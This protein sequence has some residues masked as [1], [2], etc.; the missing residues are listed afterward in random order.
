M[1]PDPPTS[2]HRT[3]SSRPD[4]PS[5]R[6]ADLGHSR[7]DLSRSARLGMPEAVFAAG[8]Q[9]AQCAEI[10]ERM[11]EESDDPVIVTRCGPPHHDALSALSPER[12]W[13]DTL[14]W[15]HA[16]SRQATVA[17]VSGGTSDQPV[18]DECA[19]TLCAMGVTAR[20]V[21]DVGVAGLHRL[22][23]ALDELDEAQVIVTIAGMEAA[24]PT[25]LAGLVP[26]PIVSVPTSVGYGN[27][28]DGLT[29]L[30]S[31]MSSCAP[32]ISVVGIDNGYGAACA[33]LRILG[34]SR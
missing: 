12:T 25:V 6:I 21:R 7:V 8:K 26:T 29:A 32:G 28:F 9:P 5:G 2:A 17:I 27:T 11:L 33:T 13:S 16:P 15:R 18:L 30:L 1:N 34:A 31:M 19:G 10:V 22:L 20:V 24:L 23:G 4:T 3:E 14:T